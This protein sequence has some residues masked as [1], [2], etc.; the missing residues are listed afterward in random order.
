[1][2]ARSSK[3]IVI[4]NNNTRLVDPLDDDD[5]GI[6]LCRTSLSDGGGGDGG[7]ACTC[8]GGGGG[9]VAD[10]V[11]GDLAPLLGFD[12]VSLTVIILSPVLSFHPPA[13]ISGLIVGRNS[14]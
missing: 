8:D 11:A 13:G 7:S 9:G 1:M 12:V 3:V 4:Y 14:L 6:A 10:G 2:G 5:L